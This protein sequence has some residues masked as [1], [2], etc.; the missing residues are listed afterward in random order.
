MSEG[1]RLE[2]QMY[3]NHLWLS[4]ILQPPMNFPFPQLP[5][6]HHLTWERPLFNPLSPPINIEPLYS[7]P[8][9]FH[10]H[11]MLKDVLTPWSDLKIT[12][13]FQTMVSSEVRESPPQVVPNIPDLT[14][15]V[16]PIHMA[17]LP[18]L[19]TLLIEEVNT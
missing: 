8:P 16:F 17:F 14:N 18:P 10:P 15:Q 11:Q 6:Y 2:V 9:F 19:V 7:P 3:N 1:I 4:T 5:S 13:I 12:P